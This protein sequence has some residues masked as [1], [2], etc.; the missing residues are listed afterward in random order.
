ME[1]LKT[2][3]DFV[4]E[5]Y[6]PEE[7]LYVEG[8]TAFNDLINKLIDLDNSSDSTWGPKTI[9]SISGILKKVK[10][11]QKDYLKIDFE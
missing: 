4:N 8:E 2:F 3:G 10:D 9:K 11:L 1:K 7:R 6:T 5:S